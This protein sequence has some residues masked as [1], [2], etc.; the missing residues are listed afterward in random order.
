ME[1]TRRDA[2]LSDR[3]GMVGYV[4]SSVTTKVRRELGGLGSMRM[5]MVNVGPPSGWPW[6]FGAGNIV[7]H[8]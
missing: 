7:T 6:V 2:H 5:R 1:R 3:D 8:K 4:A